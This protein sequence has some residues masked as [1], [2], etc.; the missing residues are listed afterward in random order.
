MST[1]DVHLNR[2]F[3]KQG[4]NVCHDRRRLGHFRR[5]DAAETFCAFVSYS[6]QI[7]TIPRVHKSMTVK[8]IHFGSSNEWQILGNCATEIRGNS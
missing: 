4:P 7:Y 8:I 5:S 2:K 1:E 3:Q 6:N